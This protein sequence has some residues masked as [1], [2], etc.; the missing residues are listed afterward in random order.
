MY[1]KRILLNTPR[2]QDSRFKVQGR[3]LPCTLN[4]ESWIR[5]AFNRIRI[6]YV[7]IRIL[8]FDHC[9]L[10]FEPVVVRSIDTTDIARSL[11]KLNTGTA[12]RGNISTMPCMCFDTFRKKQL[13][14][15]C[16]CR[17]SS[18]HFCFTVRHLDLD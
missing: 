14:Y 15:S 5:G 1:S 2:I 3:T 12:L 10:Y 7:C 18:R 8:R 16:D 17:D 9:I 13:S 11:R 6:E 4:L